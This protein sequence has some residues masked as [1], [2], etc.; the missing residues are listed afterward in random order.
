MKKENGSKV[1]FRTTRYIP[2]LDDY[3]LPAEVPLDPKK[4]K[5]NRFAGKVKFKHGG[6]RENAGRKPAPEQLV[7][8]RIYLY[9]RHVKILEKIDKN[10]SAAIRK[11]VDASQKR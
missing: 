1:A 2:K 7:S 3:E 8:K 5:R 10:V 11:L 9:P 6:A 4:M